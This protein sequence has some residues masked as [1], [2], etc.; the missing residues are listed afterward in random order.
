MV[1][2]CQTK[3]AGLQ[4]WGEKRDRYCAANVTIGEACGCRCRS[5]LRC[6]RCRRFDLPMA[7]R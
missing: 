1:C 7:A 4:L 3:A 2:C 6:G 5:R